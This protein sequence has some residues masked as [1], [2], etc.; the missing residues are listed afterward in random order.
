MKRR[1]FA[2]ILILIFSIVLAAC[3]PETSATRPLA[4]QTAQ[5]TPEPT[6]QA[7]P[8]SDS[9]MGWWNDV[10]FYEIFVTAMALGIFRGSS[11]SSIILM[12][13]TQ[14][15]AMTSESGASG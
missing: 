12:M 6:V 1:A 4:T 9:S 13:A 5:S 2:I 15:P 10:V 3:V 14:T 11:P 8:E 7:I